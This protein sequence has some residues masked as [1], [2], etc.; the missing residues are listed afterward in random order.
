MCVCVYVC[1]CVCVCVC[2]RVCMCVCARSQMPPLSQ[3]ACVELKLLIGPHTSWG[4][5]ERFREVLLLAVR[6]NPV[7][8]SQTICLKVT[9]L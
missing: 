4:P 8:I 9:Q 3:A 5:S 6:D 2:A 1:V 7:A